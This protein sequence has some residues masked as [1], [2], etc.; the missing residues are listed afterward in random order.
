MVNN[1]LLKFMTPHPLFSFT[2]FCILFTG[3][4]SLTHRKKIYPSNTLETED[5]TMD[6]KTVTSA[7]FEDSDRLIN[8]FIPTSLK[9][10]L[11]ICPTFASTF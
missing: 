4:N 6:V 8:Y 10:S 3:N 9:I 2:L 7:M 11:K 5:I 1:F